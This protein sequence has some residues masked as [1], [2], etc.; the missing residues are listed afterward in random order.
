MPWLDQDPPL[1]AFLAKVDAAGL[2]KRLK[3][4]PYALPGGTVF[5]YSAL[6]FATRG[7]LYDSL[8]WQ[9]FATDL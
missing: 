6:V 9:F 4:K 3:T 1:G 2:A 5:D 7:A 8:E